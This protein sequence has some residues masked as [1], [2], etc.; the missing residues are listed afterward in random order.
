MKN[1]NYTIPI[2]VDVTKNSSNIQ[3]VI[4]I[5]SL[6]SP[7]KAG[8][9]AYRASL[10]LNSTQ[11]EHLTWENIGCE[12]YTE[13]LLMNYW[14]P[15]LG[16]QTPAPATKRGDTL[17]AKVAEMSRLN[18]LFPKCKV[19]FFARES[20]SKPWAWVS[21]EVIQN[22]GDKAN[23]LNMLVPYLSQ[24]NLDILG[25][26]S[27]IGIQFISEGFTNT[28]LPQNGDL[29]TVKG[30]IRIEL[31]KWDTGVTVYN[32]K[33]EED[34]MPRLT[35]EIIAFGGTN[36]PDNWLPCDGSERLI[37]IYPALYQVLGTTYGPLTNGLGAAGVTH[38]QLPD[39][40]GRVGIG[41]GAGAGLTARNFGVEV[42]AETVTLSTSEMPSHTHAQNAHN[43]VQDA[44]N[45]VQDAHNHVQ[46][47]HGHAYNWFAG[48]NAA[49]SLTASGGV[50]TPTANANTTSNVA[51]TNQTAIATNQAATATNQA[52]TATNAPTGGGAAHNN[53]QP[54]LV[55]GYL[56]YAK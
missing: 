18:G 36:T 16:N 27:Q 19:L 49:S 31:S 8:L 13:Q 37:S 44:H 23:Y 11:T 21:V 34:D 12:V 39:L 20:A 54:S 45:H 30:A 33:I 26:T 35:G 47:A 1:P 14:L 38:F 10:G 46:N 15:S 22:Y 9:A 25:R 7:A 40:R 55:I 48:A 52:A 6:A 24:G 5:D 17:A 53:M 29:L 41:A 4:D 43:H 56:I 2:L 32:A 3:T 28:L 50:L 42:G 51:A